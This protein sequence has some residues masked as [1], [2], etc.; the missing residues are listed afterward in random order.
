MIN[1]E[2]EALRRLPYAE[3]LKTGH[4]Q[5]QRKGALHRAAHSCQACKQF[6]V[7][8]DVHHNTYVRL[9]CE[10]PSDLLVLC[11]DCH[12]LFSANG[13]LADPDLD[14]LDET[15]E[16]D[17][18]WEDE[19]D[20][21]LIEAQPGRL[22]SVMGHIARHP[23]L[24][25]TGG[26]LL[27]SF[28]VD[29]FV[30]FDPFGVIVGLAATAVVCWKSGDLV[31]GA[32]EIL[33]PGSNQ[34]AVREGAEDFA[35]RYLGD[36]PVY[37]DQSFGAKMRRLFHLEEGEI[38]DAPPRPKGS[39]K[40]LPS[41]TDEPLTYERIA[42]WLEHR[43]INDKQFFVLLKRLD[44]E[45]D[46]SL[47]GESGESVKAPVG[48]GESGESAVKFNAVSPELSPTVSPEEEESV[49]QAYFT[50]ARQKGKVT[51]EDIKAALQ[52]N[53]KKHYIVK[54]VCDKYSIAMPGGK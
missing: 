2:I 25:L 13:K 23:R 51:R 45:I 21:A 19:A 41:N 54:V 5:R 26:T 9:G 20:T 38:V 17:E 50:I 36:Y 6:G 24:D 12:E 28:G 43:M 1:E 18:E 14:P 11:H 4:W 32:M 49:L 34:D 42:T 8:L 39:I 47:M 27:L 7:Q 40:E 29:I 52:L 22:Q 30:R 33:V 53:N 37:A 10:L 3:Y 31:Q 44:N 15:D 46:L 48:P 35:D 16:Y